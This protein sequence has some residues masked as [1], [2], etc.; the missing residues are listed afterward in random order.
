MEAV[1]G[2]A[3]DGQMAEVG[4][5]EAAA[6]VAYAHGDVLM[7]AG[8]RRLGDRG[9]RVVAAALW[10]WV[11]LGGGGGVWAQGTAR[12]QAAFRAARAVSDPGQRVAAL[13]AFMGEFPESGLAAKA[14]AL[15]LETEL[16]AFPERT[17]EIHA[18]AAAEVSGAAAGLERWIEE[19]HVADMLANAGTNGADL[20]DAKVWAGQA[21]AALTEESFRRET[22][23]S[24]AKY[25]LP[26]LTPKQVHR[27]FVGY[28]A[29]FLAALANVE[30]RLGQTAA[31]APLLEEA[32]R[33]EPLSGEVNSLRGQM[34]LARQQDAEALTDFER[35]EAAG[36]LSE[37]WRGEMLRLYEARNPDGEPGLERKVDAVYEGMYPPVFTLKPRALP[38]GGHTVLLEL[39][40]GSGCE[41]CVAPDLAVESLLR[42]YSRQDLVVL[43]WDENVPRPDPLTNWSS[44]ARAYEYGVGQTPEAFLDGAPLPVAG[45]SREDAENVVIGFADEL[46]DRAAEPTGVR[47]SLSAQRNAGGKITATATVTTGRVAGVAVGRTELHFALVQDHIRYSGENGIRF[48][49]MVVRAMESGERVGPAQGSTSVTEATFDLT[50]LAKQ[51]R[52]YLDAYEKG[53]EVYGEVRFLT[54]DIPIDPAQLAVVAWVE[55][56]VTH[57]VLQTAYAPVPGS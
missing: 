11:V 57:E 52:A 51:L 26:P 20:A 18:L 14:N 29:A 12:D 42:T 5:V 24:Q 35:A 46:E 53:N 22:A 55:N 6:E 2:G 37:R 36:G 25:K 40:T 15:A 39:F 56:P 19:A 27:D 31:A 43:E 10:G 7:V 17:E 33:L 4:R 8:L 50:A 47:I 44:E 13:K 9:V 48:H 21:V 3:G 45:A 28:R 16:A 34:A 49:R 38:A 54:K 23:A 30:L 1:A 32:F 41:P